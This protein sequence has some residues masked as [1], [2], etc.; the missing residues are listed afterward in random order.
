MFR[1]QIWGR[2]IQNHCKQKNKCQINFPTRAA[3]DRGFDEAVSG[4]PFLPILAYRIHQHLLPIQRGPLGV[5][6]RDGAV[7]MRTHGGAASMLENKFRLC[8]S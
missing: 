3:W 4:C 1:P 7:A 2:M 8:L 6:D 5:E